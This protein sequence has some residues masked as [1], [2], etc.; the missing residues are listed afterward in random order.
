MTDAEN[1]LW[2]GIRKKQLKGF[3]FYRQKNLGNYIVDF[4]CPGAKLSLKWMVDSTT[5][6]LEKSVTIRRMPLSSLSGFEF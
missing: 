4:Y 1:S 2:S 5:P 3:Q 6:N